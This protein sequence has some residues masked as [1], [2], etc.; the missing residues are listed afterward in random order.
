MT[1]AA[2]V[3]RF[4]EDVLI[5]SESISKIIWRDVLDAD[6]IFISIFTFNA[7][8]GYELAAYVRKN[9]RATVVIGG[10][11]ATLYYTEAASHCD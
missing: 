4:E 2:I 1:L 7:I 5:Y 3:K 6:V 8:R 10:L 9:S 11:H